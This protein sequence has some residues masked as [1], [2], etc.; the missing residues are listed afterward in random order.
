M[1]AIASYRSRR[2]ETASPHQIVVM[3]YQELLRRIELGAV[4]LEKSSFTEAT[5]HFHHA[6]EIL[7]ELLASLA[8]VAGAEDLVANLTRLYKWGA[9]EL[10]AVARE[11]DPARARGVARVFEPLLDGWVETL[12]RGAR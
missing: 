10:V 11:R 2:V 6:R 5:T 7:V 3:L 12:V 9:A 4:H 1:N 8:P